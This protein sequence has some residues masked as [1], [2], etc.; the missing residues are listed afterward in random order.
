MDEN[1]YESPREIVTHGWKWPAV[2]GL[3]LIA[4]IVA[5]YFLW[6]LIKAIQALG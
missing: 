1:P 2:G 5:G 4:L 3:C 6:P